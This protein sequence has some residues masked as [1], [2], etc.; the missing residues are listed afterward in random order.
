MSVRKNICNVLAQ[1][2]ISWGANQN[3]LQWAE[4][5]LSPTLG[6]C[7]S[8]GE[9]GA[10]ASIYMLQI[11]F[12]GTLLVKNQLLHFTS[13][14]VEVMWPAQGHTAPGRTPPQPNTPGSGGAST[15]QKTS[16]STNA[17]GSPSC[18][19]PLSLQKQPY[20][21]TWTIKTQHIL[22]F[23]PSSDGL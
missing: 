18:K 6:H 5:P 8:G 20:L 16:H 10:W 13:E 11:R 4:F 17:R 14:E 22:F 3:P 9:D 21:A 2:F 7:D 23:S 19:A 12:R 1:M 15:Y